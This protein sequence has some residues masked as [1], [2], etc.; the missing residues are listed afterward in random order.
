MKLIS[1]LTISLT[2]VGLLGCTGTTADAD[3]STTDD[4]TDDGTDD[5]TDDDTDD[6]TDGDTDT[7]AADPDCATYCADFQASCSAEPVAYADE[8]ECLSVCAAAAIPA[9]TAADTAGNTL[10]C[11]IYHSGAA[12]AAPT[13]H[14]VHA[15]L[16]GG[17]VC[18]TLVENYCSIIDAVC[19][20]GN[21][22]TWA[23]D[24]ATDAG[25]YAAGTPGDAAG[26]TLDCRVYHL[27]V[28]VSDP[29]THCGHAG[30]SGD[31]VCVD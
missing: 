17:G 30:P 23:A 14:C 8:A 2:F 22:P 16:F 20:D 4:A 11:R 13:D 31:G 7:D 1:N 21:A 24:C 3:K 18:G 25:A 29:D 6:D 26:D 28:A 9:G 12:A 19:V 27:G 10:G 15:S 5:G